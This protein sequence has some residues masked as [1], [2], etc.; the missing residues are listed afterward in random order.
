MIHFSSYAG[1]LGSKSSGGKDG[2]SRRNLGRSL[3][4]KSMLKSGKEKIKK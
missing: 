1:S 3:S 4:W 2:A